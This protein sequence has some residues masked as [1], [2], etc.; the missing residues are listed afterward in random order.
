MLDVGD[1]GCPCFVPV[2]DLDPEPDP[3]PDPLGRTKSDN[4]AREEGGDDD[5]LAPLFPLS[6]LSIPPDGEGSV[7]VGES[8]VIGGYAIAT[9]DTLF[10]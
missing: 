7:E 8:V 2:G 4:F 5:R 3:D 9:D 1:D 10:E 6:S